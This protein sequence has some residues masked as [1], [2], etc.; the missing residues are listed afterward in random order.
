MFRIGGL[1][2]IVGSIDTPGNANDVSVACNRAYVADGVAGLRI[3]DITIPATPTLLGAL[4][5]PGE[6]NDL[7]IVGNRVYLADGAA[8]LQI[9]DVSDPSAPQLQAPQHSWYR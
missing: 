4:D 3:I 2:H 9:I 7:V 8:G 1:P 5:T 6:A